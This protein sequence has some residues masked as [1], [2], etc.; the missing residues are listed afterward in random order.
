M[1]VARKIQKAKN[2]AYGESYFTGSFH[3][4]VGNFTKADLRRSRNW[5]SGWI[6]Y[7]AKY[8][9]IKNAK[10]KKALEIGCSI[11]GAANVLHDIGYDVLATDISD[12]ALKRAKKLSPHITFL[13]YDVSKPFQ[14]KKQFD[15]IYAFEVIEHLQNPLLSLRN[16]YAVLKPGGTIICSTQYPYPFAFDEPTHISIKHPDEWKNIF[17]KA[18][19][20]DIAIKRGT[21]IPYLYRYHKIFSHGIPLAVGV[22]WINSTVFIIAKKSAR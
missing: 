20:H 18:G 8:A 10:G 17:T 11:G 15:L 3:G 13:P 22:K 1:P 21:F 2:A 9:D 4:A 5:F 12:Y 19:F 14:Q 6:T 16:L 7:L